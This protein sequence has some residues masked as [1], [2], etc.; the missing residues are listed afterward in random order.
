MEF[1]PRE[2]GAGVAEGAA[3]LSGCAPSQR[4]C[5]LEES[6]LHTPQLARRSGVEAQCLVVGNKHS[7]RERQW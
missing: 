3:R 5:G 2:K 4:L 7:L 1:L 6:V